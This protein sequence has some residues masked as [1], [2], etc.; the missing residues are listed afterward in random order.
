MSNHTI[1]TLIYKS[2]HEL[3]KLSDRETK[4]LLRTMEEENG[5][6]ILMEEGRIWKW[7]RN[8]LMKSWW[9]DGGNHENK[10]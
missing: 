4:F 1:S 9:N 10:D 6:N 5:M 3:T 7:G 8:I 2:S